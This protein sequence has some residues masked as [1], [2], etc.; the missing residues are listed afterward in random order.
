MKKSNKIVNRTGLT[1][2][3]GVSLS[4]V[5]RWIMRG[6]PY[7]QKGG[8]GKE[9]QF[10]LSDV[11]LWHKEYFLK[12][13]DTKSDDILLIQKSRALREHFRALREQKEYEKLA[14]S[15][16]DVEVVKTSAFNRG[17]KVRDAILSI[18]DRIS[19]ILAAENDTHRIHEILTNELRQALEG[20]CDGEC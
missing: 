13:G 16:I 15:L 14:K 12:N 6:C 3:F 5:D 11:I 8:K 2:S 19:S 1:K 4:T 18:P 7:K 20:L 10:K 9:W 17:R